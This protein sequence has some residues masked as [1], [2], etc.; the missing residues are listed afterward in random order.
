L[1]LQLSG[2]ETVPALTAMAMAVARAGDP[3]AA[4]EFVERALSSNSDP[5]TAARFAAMPLVALGEVEQ[6][7]RL[8]ESIRPRGVLLRATL[9]MPGFDPIRS[10]SR[11]QALL[12]GGGDI[13]LAR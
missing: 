9:R 5:A 10:D 13:E 3:V 1:A 4:R 2:G 8:L 6:A 12:E 11:F 7:L